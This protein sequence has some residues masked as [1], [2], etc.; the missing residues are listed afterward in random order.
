[1]KFGMSDV[2][3]KVILRAVIPGVERVRVWHFH[4]GDVGVK[5]SSLSYVLCNQFAVIGSS[6]LIPG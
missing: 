6:P 1:M 2:I 4:M 5:V 3:V